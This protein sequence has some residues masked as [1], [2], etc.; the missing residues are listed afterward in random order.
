MLNICLNSTKSLSLLM[1]SVLRFTG[2]DY[3]S[4]TRAKKKNTTVTWNYVCVLA[5]YIFSN[6]QLRKYKYTSPLSC[7]QHAFIHIYIIYKYSCGSALVT[8]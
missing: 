3:F 8:V 7:I 6:K 2:S 5:Y 4:Q 1:F